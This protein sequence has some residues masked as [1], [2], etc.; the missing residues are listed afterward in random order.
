MNAVLF[1]SILLK[2]GKPTRIPHNLKI[3]VSNILKSST[4]PR[5]HV[6]G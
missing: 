1:S 3:V 6:L 2:A 4:K 5:A